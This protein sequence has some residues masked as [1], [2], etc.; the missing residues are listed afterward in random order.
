MAC[1]TG[2]LGDRPAST[3]TCTIHYTTAITSPELLLKVRKL[4][5]FCISTD[6]ELRAPRELEFLREHDSQHQEQTKTI[7]E[8]IC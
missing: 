2:R 5:Q 3:D 7:K 4:I 8:N 6:I 1:V